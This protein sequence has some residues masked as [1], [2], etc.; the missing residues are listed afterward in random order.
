MTRVRILGR[1]FQSQEPKTSGYSY[2]KIVIEVNPMDRGGLCWSYRYR[3][4]R[5]EI[6]LCMTVGRLV[7]EEKG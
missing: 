5:H 2:T 1:L 4:E 6:L 7:F 3:F